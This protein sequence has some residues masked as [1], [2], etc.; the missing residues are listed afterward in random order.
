M[1]RVPPLVVVRTSGLVVG[2]VA[3][4]LEGKVL[5][6]E[7]E[8]VTMVVEEEEAMAVDMELQVVDMVEKLQ[9]RGTEVLNVFLFCFGL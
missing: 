2:L 1:R 8:V 5:T 6:V 3:V 9:V 7:E 4:T